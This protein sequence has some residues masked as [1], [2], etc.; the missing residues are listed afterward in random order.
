VP[1]QRVISWDRMLSSPGCRMAR[2]AAQP[3]T[4]TAEVSEGT[5]HSST[6]VF[7]LR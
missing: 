7:V 5:M 2:T 4:Y 3:G 1:Y 6:V